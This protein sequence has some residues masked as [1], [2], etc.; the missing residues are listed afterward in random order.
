M[1][2]I[3]MSELKDGY[4][5]EIDARNQN[6]GIWFESVKGFE[7]ARRKFDDVFLFI[8]YE[9]ETG[10]P[11]G[12]A[13]AFREIEKAPEGLSDAERLKY[14]LSHSGMTTYECHRF[15]KDKSYR[16]W[17]ETSGWYNFNTGEHDVQEQ[18][19]CKE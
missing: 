6:R 13:R 4:L 16:K 17:V 18:M 14:L 11:F 10:P 9:W 15:F 7:I 5:Y 3:P 1:K 2:K 8:E 12:T 19:G